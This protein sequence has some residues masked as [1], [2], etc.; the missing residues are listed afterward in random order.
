MHRHS[1]DRFQLMSWLLAV[2]AAMVGFYALVLFLVCGGRFP[3]FNAH[4]MTNAVLAFTVG[5]VLLILNIFVVSDALDGKSWR[6][7]VLTVISALGAAFTLVGYGWM[8]VAAG[9]FS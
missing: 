6:K 3:A 7:P 5:M 4:D 1:I 2:F 9:L 8:F